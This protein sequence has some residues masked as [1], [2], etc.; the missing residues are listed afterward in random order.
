MT[1]AA[2]DAPRFGIVGRKNAGKTTLVARLVAELTGRGL[3]VAT[4][5]HAHHSLEVDR[6]GTDSWKHREAGAS[7]VALVGPNRWAIM[8]ELRGAPEPGLDDIVSRLS[9]CDIVLIEGF[10]GGGHPKLEV[11]RGGAPLD[12]ADCPNVVAVAEPGTGLDADMVQ[13]IAD[14]A[15]RSAR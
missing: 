4:V 11:R 10:K 6:E 14:L 3:R 5:K 8:A 2:S 1:R 15:L 7:E 13:A 12:P 9:P